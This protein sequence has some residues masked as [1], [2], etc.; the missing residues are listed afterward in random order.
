MVVFSLFT[1]YL[2]TM[3]V[4]EF[5]VVIFSPVVAC[6]SHSPCSINCDGSSDTSRCSEF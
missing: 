4:A 3:Y 2:G 1:Q 6:F 5:L